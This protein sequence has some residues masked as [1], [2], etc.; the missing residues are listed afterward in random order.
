MIAGRTVFNLVGPLSNP[1]R[2]RFQMIGAVSDEIGI[3]LARALQ[4]LGLE[5]AIVVVGGDGSDDVSA[6]AP[7]ELYV[8][9]S[10]DIRMATLD[11]KTLGVQLTAEDLECGD[12]V[13]NA[14]L[15][16]LLLSKKDTQN[17]IS[18]WMCLSAAVALMASGHTVTPEEGYARA[19]AEMASGR[20]WDLVQAYK[21]A[22]RE[23]QESTAG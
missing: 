3:K 19:K 2:V 23:W 20:P 9:T 12:A 6:I 4:R 15:F 1:A 11:P 5:R 14:A 8:V 16:S 22:A 7:S 21:T 13:D 18:Q 10:A 17:P